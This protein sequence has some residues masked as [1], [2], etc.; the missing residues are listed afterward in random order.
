MNYKKVSVILA[1]IFFSIMIFMT[2]SARAIHNT[3]IPNVTVFRLT[4]EEFK[5]VSTMEDGLESYTYIKQL[6]AI[7]KEIYEQGEVFTIDYQ[8]IN[9]EERTVARLT[10]IQV[11]D[12]NDAFY[13]VIDPFIMNELFIGYSSRDI[14][15]GDEVYVMN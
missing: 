4:H 15:D 11:G 8:K 9:G 12:K 2:F 10:N 6:L 5:Y 14:Q 7:P 13:E 3:M 1:V